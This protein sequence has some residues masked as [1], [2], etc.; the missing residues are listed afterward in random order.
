MMVR[1][2]IMVI[3][4]ILWLQQTSR[5]K[6]PRNQQL[7]DS[8]TA[9]IAQP[10]KAETAFCRNPCAARQN[11]LIEAHAAV[12]VLWST[13]AEPKDSI[14]IRARLRFELPGSQRHM[15]IKF[16]GQEMHIIGHILMVLSQNREPQ[17]RPQI[18]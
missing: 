16:S 11:G 17:Y 5:A 3:L 13:D 2:I 14:K 4:A 6:Q 10:K 12:H 9:G 1:T 15:I 8:C 7:F 18:L